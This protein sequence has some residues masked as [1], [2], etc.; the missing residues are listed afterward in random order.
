MKHKLKLVTIG[1]GSSYTPELVE[2]LIHRYKTFPV[3][4]YWLVDIEEGKEKLQII[5]DLARRQI[6]KANLPI[7]VFTTLNR[8]AALKDADFVT[9]QFRV[10]GLEARSIDEAIPAKYNV[11]GQETN[12]PGGLF[13][14]LRTIPV[15]F[16][17]IKDCERLCPNAW[18]INFTNPAGIVT[19]AVFQYTNWKR[20]VGVCNLPYGMHVEMA[21]LFETAVDHLRIN[22]IGLNHLVFGVDVFVDGKEVTK[23]ALVKYSDTS[24]LGMK[25]IVNT[26]W[27]NALIE[28]L[29]VIP[30]SYLR[31][32]FQQSE[33]LAAQNEQ[34]K[35]NTTRAQVVMALED[36]LF[37]K[38]RDLSLDVKPK[39][40][41]SRGGAYYADTACNLMNSIYNDKKDVQVVNTTSNG[42]IKG[43]DFCDVVEVSC[44]ITKEGPIPITMKQLP[45]AAIGLVQQMKS[46][47][48][49]VCK[50]AVTGCY[51]DA[52][53]AMVVNPLVQ[54]EQLAKIILDE[55]LIAHQD[56][57]PQFKKKGSSNN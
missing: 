7:E 3:S 25:N 15:I 14:A 56:Y 17:I 53:L 31:Y 48:K 51:N 26:P 37:K 24:G 55:M 57:L 1:G 45:E 39:E 49:L 46:F 34:L 30:C 16:D 32:Y 44:V 21:N 33:M 4:E 2:G 36:E 10:G 8:E 42:V 12:G 35:T 22:M 20:F 23:E 41:E 13:K 9:T 19:Q 28:T 43:I 5:A 29:G 54:S 50:A 52:Y 27:S 38:Y 47:E 11:I 18:I 6:K 40:L